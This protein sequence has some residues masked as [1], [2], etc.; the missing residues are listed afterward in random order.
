MVVC[1]LHQARRC[2]RITP[3]FAGA[4][5]AAPVHLFYITDI[6]TITTRTE[7]AAEEGTVEPLLPSS[8]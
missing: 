8:A 5:L 6:D 2:L 3:W 4:L 1:C 7:R